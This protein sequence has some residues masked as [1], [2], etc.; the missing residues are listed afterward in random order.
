MTGRVVLAVSLAALGGLGC[1]SGQPQAEDHIYLMKYH[2]FGP[3]SVAGDLLGK[4]WYRWDYAGYASPDY[5]P[6]IDVA[7]YRNIPLEAAQQRYPVLQGKRD[8]RY[9]EYQRAVD[10]LRDH[11]RRI[12]PY[13]N[14]T[15]EPVMTLKASLRRILQ[16]FQPPEA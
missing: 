9:V 14:S 11:I 7:I 13:G 10:F 5:K 8:V 12:D 1:A 16:A 4:D 2:D 15:Q 6:D 3:Q